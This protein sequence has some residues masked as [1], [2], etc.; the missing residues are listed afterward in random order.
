MLSQRG[1]SQEQ[2]VFIDIA[3]DGFMPFKAT[4]SR[5]AWGV[6]LRVKNV[7]PSVHFRYFNV[8]ELALWPQASKPRSD[9]F[10]DKVNVTLGFRQIIDELVQLSL[11]G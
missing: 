9:G 3:H 8:R 11:P 7:D 10:V 6:W 4:S 5:H 1:I 2:C